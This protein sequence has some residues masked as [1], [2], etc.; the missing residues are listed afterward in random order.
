[1]L[2]EIAAAP[3]YQSQIEGLL[4]SDVRIVNGVLNR[5]YVPADIISGIDTVS[6]ADITSTQT[7]ISGGTYIAAFNTWITSVFTSLSDSTVITT[8]PGTEFK[9][10]S[11]TDIVNKINTTG[12]ANITASASGN[13]LRIVKTTTTSTVPFSLTI[14]AASANAEVG[15]NTTTQTINA[16]S[17]VV[18]TTPNLTMSQVLDQIN[19]A[20]FA[21]ITAQAYAP[22]GLLLNILSSNETLY[23]GAGT[24]NSIIGL[25]QGVVPATS[26]VSTTSVATDLTK[27]IE[28]I[29]NANISGVTASNSSNKLKITSINSTLVIG[30]GTAN[31]TVGFIAQT[32]TATQTTIS[33]VFNA[34]VT[35]NGQQVEVFREVENDPTIFSIWVADDSTQ[36]RS[37]LG[38]SV[39]QT[40][41]FGFSIKK[42]CAGITPADDAMIMINVADANIQAHNLQVGDYV[43]IRGSN[44]VPS[45]DGI[46]KVTSN[47]PD[48]TITLYIDEYIEQEGNAGN[49][50]PIR[51]MRFSNYASLL[52]NFNTTTNGIYNYNFAGIRQNNQQKP[53]LAFVDDN[54]NGKPAVYKWTGTFD[55]NNGHLNGTWLE[56]RAAEPQARNDLIENVK[57]YDAER[58]TIISTI[59]TFDPAKGIIPGFISEEI[60]FKL[61]ADIASY[62]YNSLQGYMENKRTWGDTEVGKRWWDLTSAVYLDYEQGS[63]DYQQSNWGRLF[64]GASIDIYEWTRS[65][66]VPDQW[67]TLVNNNTLINGKEATGE[68][69]YKVIDGEKIYSWTEQTFYNPIKRTTETQ[70][71]F[72][73]K[74]KTNYIGQRD[75]TV[76]QLARLLENPTAF[77]ITWCAASGDS[78]LFLTNIDNLV[79]NNSVVQVNQI[80]NGNTLPLTEWTLLSDGD[81]DSTIPEYFHIKIRDSLVGYNQNTRVYTFTDFNIA[82]VYGSDVVVREGTKYY[83]SLASSN[84]GNT[85][86][87]DTTQTYWR[88]IL[89]YTLPQ[90]TMQDDIEVWMGQPLPDLGLH[91][92]NRYGQ[93]TRPRQSLYRN[94]VE[95]RQNFISSANSLLSEICVVSEINGW[96][97]TLSGTWTDGVVTYDISKYW[98][99]VD[100]VHTDFDPTIKPDSTVTYKSQLYPISNY[101]EGSE[102]YVREAM[103]TDNI[104]RPE[105]WKVVD[106]EWKLVWKK[107]GTIKLS[108]E[109]WNQSKFGHGFDTVGFDIAGFDSDTS[110]ILKIVFDELRNTLFTGRFAVMYNRL[111]FNCL[112]QAVVDNTTDDFAFKTTYVKLNINHPVLLNKGK[113]QVTTPQP[114]EDF[115][116]SIKPFHTKL[117]NTTEKVTHIEAGEVTVSEQERQA[118]ITMKYD[119]HCGRTWA[120]DVDLSGGSFTTST[121]DTTLESAFTTTVFDSTYDGNIFV[122]PVEEGWCEELYPVDFTENI[123]IKV[124]TNASGSTEDADSRAFRMTYFEP[125]NLEENSVIVDAAKTTV[126]IDVNPADTDIEVANASVLTQVNGVVW[127]G[128]ERVEY[129]AVDGNTLRYCNRGTYGTSANVHVTGTVVTD[130]SEVYDVTSIRNF[131]HYGNNLRH[132]FNDDGVSLSTAGTTSEH[133][134]IRNAGKGT[135]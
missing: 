127:I 119:R 24:A 52:S 69:Y 128:N 123:S 33:N 132:A 75:Y 82:T 12:I 124:Q 39:Y 58:Q 3:S 111:W 108:E 65:P 74:N 8:E 102:V 107:K 99:F 106:G 62:N 131:A 113:Y 85:P 103:H 68:A 21:G 41:E 10:Y 54:G 95:A 105:I 109:L 112:Y 29:N 129:G 67:E 51:K 28:L 56:V 5:T 4:S 70:Y 45:I 25:T 71:F 76:Y 13:K 14:S 135:L 104:N 83:L 42:A 66:V 35:R 98:N 116:N 34:F 96:D 72:W 125:Y 115:L 50:Y 23:I 38:Y 48:S 47:D 94:L 80:Y 27:A 2:S 110:N 37:N 93:L 134:N 46:H 84:V 92:Y 63:I 16:T 15:F 31:S 40:M 130:A 120:G 20:G 88:E 36:G 121:Y 44:T 18:T 19:N 97:R 7:A 6:N 26:T 114:V 55:V 61:T 100:W 9:E 30:S 118:V 11:L 17:T 64:D 79:T 77:D 1:M 60:D 78:F 32:Y 91:E 122:Q 126:Q 117:R 59:E 73:V 53:I 43:L 81:P 87:A 49:I 22:A 57:I 133:A 89:E 86:S 90:D 101:A